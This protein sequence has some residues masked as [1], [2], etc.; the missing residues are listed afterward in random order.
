MKNIDNLIK[1][2]L[3]KSLSTLINE[4]QIN[5]FESNLDKLDKEFNKYIINEKNKISNKEEYYLTVK[6]LLKKYNNI[7]L[8]LG[9]QYSNVETNFLLSSIIETKYFIHG[10]D[11]WSED[12]ILEV[13]DKLY[14]IFSDDNL[15]ELGIDISL[16]DM[17]KKGV[18]NYILL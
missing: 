13:D 18:E 12:E 17:S 11:K 1:E 9:Y 14:E 4:S 7:I 5:S 8:N 15:N 6:N 16:K 2:S 10:S 3:Y